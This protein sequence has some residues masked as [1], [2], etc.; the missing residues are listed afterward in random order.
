MRQSIH[1]LIVGLLKASHFGPTVLVVTITYVL[2]RTQ[3]SASDSLFIAFAILLGQF[4]VGWSNDLIDFPRDRAAKRLGKP[5][6]AATIT[7]STLKISIGIVLLSALI[8]SLFSPLGVSGTAI[9]FLGLLS[10][11]AYNLKLKST[12]L[13]VVPYIV[14]FGALPWAIYVAAGTKPPTW[15]V[16]GFVLFASAFHFLNVLKDL[17]SD[18]DQDV[19]GLPQVLG[20]QK[21]ILIALLLAGLGILDVVLANIRV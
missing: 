13:S 12:L 2:S 6:V 10:A 18:V 19:M 20:R 11:T 7:Q 5:L 16:L 8:I 4:V 21:S 3:F 15:I 1:S 17:D 14:S 9:H